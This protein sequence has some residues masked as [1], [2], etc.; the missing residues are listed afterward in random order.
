MHEP[1][2]APGPLQYFDQSARVGRSGALLVV[3]E[4]DEHCPALAPPFSDV[5]RPGA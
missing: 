1:L 2:F 4:I 3:V 5:T